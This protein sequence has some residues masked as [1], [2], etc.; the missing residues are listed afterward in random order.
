LSLLEYQPELPVDK[1]DKP[2]RALRAPY[3]NGL[4]GYHRPAA[5]ADFVMA[6]PRV[7]GKFI[8]ASGEKFWVRGATYGTFRPQADGG[9]ALDR[10]A[11]ERDFALMA[12]NGLNAVRTYTVPPRWLLDAAMRHGLRVM[13]GIPWEQ[14]I[15]FLDDAARRR[16]IEQRVRAA[17]RSLRA[18]PALL[19]YAI[20]NE[21]PA[22]IARWHGAR[23]IERF[24]RRLYRAAK[25][26]DPDALVTYV[27]YPTTEYLNLPFLDLVCFNVYL[28][29]KER[30]EKYLAR[31]HNLAGDRPVILAEIGLDSRRN[32]ELA[33][34]VSIDW[35]IRAAFA[36]GAAGAFVFAWTD[37]WHRGGYDI[38]DWDFGLT[39]RDRRPKPALA[40]AR[41]A[42][43][44]TPFPARADWPLISV[45]V[46]SYNGARTIRD[47]LDGLKRLKYPS[48]EVIV[49]NDGSTDATEKIASEYDFRVITTKNY[50]LSHARNV[51]WRAAA[52]EIVA[53]ID[54][55]A[56]PDSDWLVYLANAFMHTN[57]GGIGGPNVAPTGGGLI[58]DCIAHAPGGPVH[59]LVSDEEAEHIPGCNM[60]FRKAALKAIGG[61]DTQFR[62]AGD[63]VDVCWRLQKNGYTIGFTP[64]ALVWHHRRGSLAAYWKQQA[65]YGKAE[66]LLE[67]KW[68][69]KY[70]AAGH[71]TWAGRVY[72][73]GHTHGLGKKWRIYYGT[74]GGALF[75]SRHDAA[76]GLLLS[77]PLMPEWY[78]VIMALAWLSAVGIFWPPLLA[79]VPLLIL[80]LAAPLAQAFISGARAPFCEVTHGILKCL[81]MR[82]VTAWLH[83]QQPL[84][85]LC[86]RIRYDLTPWRK[87][88]VR[89]TA[90]PAPRSFRIWSEAWQAASDRLAAVEQVLRSRGASVACGGDFDEWDLEV[91]DGVFAA[92]RM[93][94]AIEEHGGGK[95]LVRFRAAPVFAKGI[96]FL[97]IGCLGM[98]LGAASDHAWIASAAIAVVAA[99]FFARSFQDCAAAMSAVVS[100]LKGMGAG[101]D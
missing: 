46:C 54:D 71:L 31:V 33:Q 23:K 32:G 24:I 7:A 39:T 50:G 64:S 11:V 3:R 1:I 51:G 60:A 38:D 22:P 49:V 56:Y 17:V 66:A 29:S 48:Y 13:V 37:E 78:L 82:A 88:G 57:H 43:A 21:I 10:D 92:V 53:Y 94:M 72:G 44:E 68:P 81:C 96:V 77:L 80:S 97:L 98:S 35:Q 55:D 2:E 18:H 84:A 70:N 12:A 75:Q 101:E 19:F 74:W 8:F 30:L 14:H 86:G 69:E 25:S 15:A 59:V 85:R 47:C 9:E 20:G 42:F 45:V 83:L 52:G 100:S 34:A 62:A 36:S 61:F 79:F 76:P 90:F 40:A 4:N 95:Q 5:A 41:K 99:I 63:D 58:A 6:R 27:N 93:R 65:G 67:R 91:R 28:E 89:G 73:N 26:V 87:R 16:S